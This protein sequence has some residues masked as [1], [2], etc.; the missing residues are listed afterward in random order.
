MQPYFL[1]HLVLLLWIPITI[2]LFTQF[3]PALAA[4]L[5]MLGGVILLPVGIGFDFPGLPSLDRWTLCSVGTLAGALLFA[6]HQLAWRS[7]GRHGD[8]FW[9]ALVVGSFFTAHSNPESLRYGPSLLPGMTLYDGIS[10][11]SRLLLSV[12]VPYFL[13]RSLFRKL[14]DVSALLGYLV[15]IGI[16]YSLLALYEV[17]MSPQLHVQL[18][19]FVPPTIQWLMVHRL[20]GYRPFVFMP[21]GLALATFLLTLCIAAVT[22]WKNRLRFRGYSMALPALFLIL[23]LA[24]CKSLG[25]FVYAALILPILFFMPSRVQARIIVVLALF[26]FAYP[27]LRAFDLVPTQ[28]LVELAATVDAERAQSLDVRFRNEKVLLDHARARLA[29][30]W[31]SWGRNRSYDLESG[32]D[33]TVTDGYW[34]LLLGTSGLV[35]YCAFFGLLLAPVLRAMGKL[36]SFATRRERSVVL[37][38]AWMVI[39]YALDMLPNGLFNYYPIFLSGILAATTAHAERIRRKPVPSGKAGAPATAANPAH[40]SVS[41][42]T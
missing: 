23:T 38:I 18:Y 2:F 28:A 26:L 39:V 7:F 24:L 42:L 16:A 8:A 5:A 30:G 19:G 31:G 17:R 1:A 21:H 13:A 32:S 40:T 14:Q 11:A 29:F 33:L 20:G 6:P 35:G 41:E 12:G 37:A 10:M 3:R 9:I 4:A 15:A 25:S 22:A 36:R 34:I 27:A